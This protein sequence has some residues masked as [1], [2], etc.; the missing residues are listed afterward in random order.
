[1]SPPDE[2]PAQAPPP[3]SGPRYETL[4]DQMAAWMKARLAAAALEDQA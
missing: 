4:I 2:S 3:G 1:M